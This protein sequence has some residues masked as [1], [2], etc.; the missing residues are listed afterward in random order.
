MKGL[1]ELIFLLNLCG[2]NKLIKI[3]FHGIEN[4]KQI[5]M[6]KI[7]I[8][9]NGIPNDSLYCNILIISVNLRVYILLV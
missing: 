3:S 6:L 4:I 2:F 8:T 7:G 5:E 9:F 1:A